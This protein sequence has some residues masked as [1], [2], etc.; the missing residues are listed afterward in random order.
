MFAVGFETEIVKRRG[1]W[2]STTFHLYLLRDAQILSVISR[3]MLSNYQNHGRA[4]GK[5]MMYGSSARR[6]AHRR[7]AEISKCMSESLR[8]HSLP[9][10]TDDG[11]SPMRSVLNLRGRVGR[12][13]DFADIQ[14]I[15]NGGG[16]KPQ[17]EIWN[18]SGHV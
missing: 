3:A 4:G 7:L 8:R 5:R 1:R 6:D 12:H 16:K 15:A 17:K 10:M 9:G 14:E 13:A 11:W 18:W 2:I